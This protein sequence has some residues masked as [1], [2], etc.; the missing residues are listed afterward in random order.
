MYNILVIN[1]K[2]CN[3][4]VIFSWEGCVDFFKQM[5][6][7]LFFLLIELLTPNILVVKI[8][9]IWKAVS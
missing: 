1:H 5:G 8:Y 9:K 6:V 4:L 2:M 3:I 7:S